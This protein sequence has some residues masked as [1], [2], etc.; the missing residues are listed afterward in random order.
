MKTF[1][2]DI[3]NRDSKITSSFIKEEI[4]KIHSVED[5]LNSEKEIL[6]KQLKQINYLLD[7]IEKYEIEVNLEK[8]NKNH[9]KSWLNKLEKKLEE[10]YLLEKDSLTSA[11]KKFLEEE[12]SKLL[13]EKEK[14]KEEIKAII[15]EMAENK[16]LLMDLYE[17]IT[18]KITKGHNLAS[19]WEKL[20]EKF[21]K[22]LVSDT[23]YDI[24]A[25]KIKKFLEK[26]FKLDKIETNI[27]FKIL[28]D[29]NLIYFKIDNS[30][31][32]YSSLTYDAFYTNLEM[33]IWE[34]YINS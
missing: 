33:P 24:W 2:E 29:S 11:D 12:K 31:I 21:G 14:L 7:L 13:F 22:K 34:W 18:T 32:P 25:D 23:Y 15:K 30:F 26:E 27:L 28:E 3:K 17:T 4:W 1:I 16:V 5:E 10:Y 6:E 20:I 19:V 8:K 9:R